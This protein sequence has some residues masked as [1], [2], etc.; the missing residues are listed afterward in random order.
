[1]SHSDE[2]ESEGRS[3]I[4]SVFPWKTPKRMGGGGV[5]LCLC[6]GGGGGG[7]GGGGVCVCVCVCVYVCVCVEGVTLACQGQ[8]QSRLCSPSSRL[9]CHP[10]M[11][12]QSW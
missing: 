4:L 7:S 10:R 9:R 2:R 12:S 11:R 6:G 5:C 8:C 3:I 1:M